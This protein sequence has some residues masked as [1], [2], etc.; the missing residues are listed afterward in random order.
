MYIYIYIY[1][2]ACLFVE[3]LAPY[4]L[5][6]AHREKK[7]VEVF[8]KLFAEKY[9]SGY[10]VMLVQF[11]MFWFR[12]IHFSFFFSLFACRSHSTSSILTNYYSVLP[13]AVFFFICMSF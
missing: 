10:F 5:K 2:P 1:V 13:V 7:R 9:S 8:V 4:L 11:C 3:R 12:M 6:H